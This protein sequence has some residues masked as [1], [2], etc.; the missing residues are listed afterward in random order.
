MAALLALVSCGRDRETPAAGDAATPPMEVRMSPEAVR[1]AGIATSPVGEAPLAPVLAVDGTLAAKPWIPEEQTA[2]SDA[3]AADARL[4]LAEASFERSSRLHAEGIVARQDL[5]TARAARDQ[6]RAAAAEADARRANLG[7][8]ADA[9]TLEGRARIWGLGSLPQ[10]ELVRVKAGQAVAVTVSAFPGHRFRG[11]VV[12]VS[13]SADPE[14]RSFTVRLAVDDPEGQLRP[15]M[16]ATFAIAL[17]AE[18][19]LSVPR[20]AVLLEGD[21]SWVWVAEDGRFRRQGVR[22]GASN[23][24]AVQILEGLSR[25]QRVVVRGA[26]ILESERLKSRLRPEE[27]D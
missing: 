14:T 16:L 24:D 8:L 9:R 11:D 4:R 10:T 2:L 7:L 27:A 20:S 15:Q 12:G 6:A 3:E 5:D 19:G 26:Q 23:A 17:P 1:A 25:D 21:G 13:R 22:T 18:P